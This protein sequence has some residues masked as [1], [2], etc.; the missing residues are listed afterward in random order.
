MVRL[1][2]R[3]VDSPWAFELRPGLNKVGRN[4]TNDFRI[5]DPSVSS[6]H[7]ELTVENGKIKVRDLGSTNG[8][9]IDEERVEEGLIGSSNTLRLG[10]VRVQIEEVLVSPA[11]PVPEAKPA[12]PLKTTFVEV[13]P[14]CAYHPELRASF[15]C[16]NC[17]G[18]FCI[19]CIKVVGR[20]RYEA[21]TVC[22][23]CNG[24]CYELPFH[25]PREKAPSLLNRL[26]Q[27]LKIPFM[28]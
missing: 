4:P 6:F 12:P 23:M 8:T 22:P 15:R 17:G 27:T 7:A 3:L 20:D 10:K 5:A 13:P 19:N 2:L 24:Q 9:Y 25:P 28:R 21:T 11:C 1:V 14:Q 18:A 16:E 26:T